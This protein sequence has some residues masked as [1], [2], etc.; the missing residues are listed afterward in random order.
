MGG[1][2]GKF[3]FKQYASFLQTLD[4]FEYTIFAAVI[5]FIWS[6]ELT[7]Y[8]KSSLGNFIMEIGQVMVTIAAQESLLQGMGHTYSHDDVEQQIKDLQRQIDELKRS[9]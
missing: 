7:M 8:E 2:Q 3:D 9:H 6:G 1:N 4:P 5:G